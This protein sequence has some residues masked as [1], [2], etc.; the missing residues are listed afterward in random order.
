M[1]AASLRAAAPPGRNLLAA[2]VA[3]AWTTSLAR[4]AEEGRRS[5][6]LRDVEREG[7]VIG[8]TYLQW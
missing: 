2:A 6:S 1:V 8:K 3:R 7:A 5:H 4:A